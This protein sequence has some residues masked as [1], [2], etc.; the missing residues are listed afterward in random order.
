MVIACRMYLTTLD[1]II[2]KHMN[3]WFSPLLIL[4]LSINPVF[5]GGAHAGG[6]HA[7][8]DAAGDSEAPGILYETIRS[9]GTEPHK[10]DYSHVS[11]TDMDSIFFAFNRPDTTG[12][13][14]GVVCNGE[15]IFSKGYGVANLDYGIPIRP[16]SRFMI[17]SISKQFAAAA[18]MMMAQEGV[19]DLDENL[20]TYIPELPEFEK[21]IT[22]RQIIHHTS[23]LRDIFNLLSLADIGLD[24][25]TTN[26]DA[27]VMLSRQQRLNFD[28]GSEHLYSNSGYFLMSVLVKNVTGMSLRDYTHKHFFEPIG[29]TATHWHDDTEI[30]VPNRVISYRP[31]SRGPGQF[32]RGNM[33]RIGA[34]GLFTTIED[35]AKWDANFIEN[36]S[37]LEDFTRTMTRPGFTH[38]RDSINYA[39][40]LRHGKYKALP[41]VGHGGSYMGFRTHYMR[42]PKYQMGFIVFCNQSDI[43]P[44]TYSRQVAD[45]Y[46]REAFSDQFREYAADYR[47]EPL[48]V[49]F[50]VILEDGDLYLKRPDGDQQRMLWTDSDRF[51]AGR[52]NLRFQRDDNGGITRFTME[53]PRTGTITFHKK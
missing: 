24:N 45:L 47:N 14:V 37:H 35:F 32:Y 34:R 53:A 9:P 17:A 7:G 8:D 15:L 11:E 23:G 40:G 39:T 50:S 2:I 28:P 22:A 10:P 3:I 29:M 38:S 16:D 4:V 33:E 18:L 25:T 31:T 26:E 41:T 42:F 19:L 51:R 13:A 43:S 36:H 52:W 1:I 21:P 12:C 30:I 44:A 6:I 49:S 48:D 20:R 5:A 46:L 27:L